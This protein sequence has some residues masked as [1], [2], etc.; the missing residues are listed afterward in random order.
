MIQLATSLQRCQQPSN[1]PLELE[2]EASSLLSLRFLLSPSRDRRPNLN[3]S[4]SPWVSSSIL[5]KLDDSSTKAP[6]QKTR[7]PVLNSVRSGDQNQNCDD[8]RTA[9][10]LKVSFGRN[11]RKVDSGNNETKSLATLCDTSSNFATKFPPPTS[12]SSRAR[13]TTF[14]SNQKAFEELFTSKTRSPPT[15]PSST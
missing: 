15:R 7:L 8:S 13:W 2:L 12:T 5:P 1:E 4:P 3:P 9:Q 6:R 14:S 11:L 10:F